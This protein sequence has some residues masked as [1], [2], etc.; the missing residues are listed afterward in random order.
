MEPNCGIPK[1]K[2]VLQN[3]DWDIIFL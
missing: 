3:A 1:V 2:I